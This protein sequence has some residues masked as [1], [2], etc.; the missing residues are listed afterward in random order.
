M[1][2]LT[3]GYGLVEG[4]LWDPQRG[5]LFSDVLFGG[6]FCLTPAGNVETLF[7]HRRGIGGIALHAAGGLIVSGGNVSFKPFN[8]GPTKRLLDADPD[9]GNVGYNDLMIDQDGRIW[10]GSLGSSPVFEDGREPSPGSL[11][12]IELD[13]TARIVGGGIELT[14]GLGFSPDGTSLYHSDSRAGVVWH[15]SIENAG[16]S[17]TVAEKTVFARS[18]DGSPDGL[19]VAADGSVW[20]ALAHGSAVAVFEPDGRLRDRLPVPQPMVTS[21]CFG[22][23]DLKDLYVVTGSQGSPG[24]RA[25]S[26]FLTRTTIAG[27]ARPIARVALPSG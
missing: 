17:V 12:V 26:V 24:D 2:K 22:G 16:G 27:L 10:V 18:N 11:H 1:R 20:V 3:T 19:A 6:V 21:L 7:E 13:G 15:Y 25:G 14:N 5:L 4:P 8:G 23:T 9:H